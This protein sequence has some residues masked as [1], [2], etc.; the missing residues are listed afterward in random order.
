MSEAL[1]GALVQENCPKRGE[2]QFLTMV[3]LQTLLLGQ[4]QVE[5]GIF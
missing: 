3:H 2:K 5:K 1:G 4:D